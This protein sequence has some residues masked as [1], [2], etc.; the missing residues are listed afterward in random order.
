[1]GRHKRQGERSR[2]PAD[3]RVPDQNPP[4]PAQQKRNLSGE[5]ARL[6][7]ES[8]ELAQKLRESTAK[9]HR[10]ISE[11]HGAMKARVLEARSQLRFARG[12]LDALRGGP[13]SANG[14]DQ[15]EFQHN[16]QLALIANHSSDALL[17]L[18]V[19]TDGVYRCL[20]LN[21]AGERARGVRAC[22]VAGKTI[23]EFFNPTACAFWKPKYEEVARDRKPLQLEAAGPDGAATEYVETRLEPV[24]D[25][26]GRCT[27]ILAISRD[28]TDRKRA[29]EAMKEARLTA[30]RA[31]KAKDHFLAVLSHEL[32][33]PLTPVLAA[34]SLLHANP[35]LDPEIRESLEMIRRNAELEARL[36]DDLLDLTR[37]AR[38]KIEL[39]KCQVS[40]GGVIMH[41]V[42]VCQPD[43]VARKLDFSVD[44]GQLAPWIVEAD[45]ARL[46]QVFWNLLKNSIKFTP[47]GGRVGIHCCPADGFVVTEV[48]DS[49]EGIEPEAL[50]RIFDAF[51]QASH[52]IARQFGGLGLG[53]A[54]SKALVE[55]HGGVIEAHSAG[56]G[57]GAT[58]RVKLPLARIPRSQ[59]PGSEDRSA[60]GPEDSSASG[61]REPAP[62]RPLRVLLVE[63]HGDTA[64]VMSR[65]LARQGYEV[66]TAG[67]VAAALELA[68]RAT[69]DLV[70]S[71]LGLPDR[72]GLD[73]MRELR[74]RGQTLPG[75][76]LSGYG[77]EDDLER[78]RAAG[79]SAHLIKP[80]DFGE[81]YRTIAAVVEHIS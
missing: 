13:A 5:T 76:A 54:I 26:G 33:T 42:E 51:E 12:L 58:F 22:E 28:I 77:Q 62:G 37:I 25:M 64:K 1:M 74:T 67:D 79:F 17:L 61:V 57:Q 46:Q 72:S 55:M 31:S 43:M 70:L 39:H 16:Q 30:E 23:D 56:K 6:Q 44:I 4:P 53:L 14:A 21:P 71:D 38:A 20:Y 34:A 73:L 60:P 9:L 35:H 36:I 40:L 68:G 32:R 65:L 66:Q 50:G 47:P 18:A 63:D 75:I 11:L 19:E 69:F 45:P 8:E 52:T 80:V 81:L 15:T 49:G 29:E 48:K 41:A 24:V 3:R 10:T 78:S 2:K 7:A 59:A 27:H